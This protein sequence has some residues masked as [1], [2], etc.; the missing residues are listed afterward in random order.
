MSNETAAA[1]VRRRWVHR[2]RWSG[3]A[4]AAAVVAAAVLLPGTA[5]AAPSEDWWFSVQPAYG[6]IVSFLPKSMHAGDCEESGNTDPNSGLISHVFIG[7]PDTHGNATII[8][9]G[10][11][12]T[13]RTHTGDIWHQSFTFR[14]AYGTPLGTVGPLDSKTMWVQPGYY[15]TTVTRTRFV[16]PALFPAIAFVEWYADC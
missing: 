8:W 15:T 3:L 4:T 1:R 10:L 5:Q 9:Y 14:T 7:T 11:T 2:R 12:R 6:G 13:S 16:D